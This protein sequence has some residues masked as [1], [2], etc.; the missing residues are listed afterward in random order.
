MVLCHTA[1]GAYSPNDRVRENCHICF[2]LLSGSLA[3]YLKIDS[4]CH[5]ERRP[6]VCQR[7]ISLENVVRLFAFVQSDNEILLMD[8]PREP[9]RDENQ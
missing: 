3:K 7:R 2:R 4:N 5:P 8:L 6:L 1:D 9:L